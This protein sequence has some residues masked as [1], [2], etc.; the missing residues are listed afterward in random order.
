MTFLLF[1]VCFDSPKSFGFPY[2][3]FLGSIFQLPGKKKKKFA[4]ILVGIA[5]IL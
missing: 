2:D 3:F 4:E 5:L 1:K